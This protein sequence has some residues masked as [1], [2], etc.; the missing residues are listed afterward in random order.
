ML[1]I[2][3]FFVLGTKLPKIYLTSLLVDVN[4]LRMN[5]FCHCFTLLNLFSYLII[6]VRFPF[7]YKV[8]LFQAGL[9]TFRAKPGFRRGIFYISPVNIRKSPPAG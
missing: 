6:F 4:R 1:Y 3:R 7:F 9:F 2:E 8:F 5:V